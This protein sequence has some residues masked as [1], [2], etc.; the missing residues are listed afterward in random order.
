MDSSVAALLGALIGA[1]AGLLGQV[2]AA[3]YASRNERRRIAVDLG[4]REW[5]RMVEYAK[6][7][8]NAEIFPLALFVHYSVELMRV[9]D[10]RRGLTATSYADIVRSNR[11]VKES[12]RAMQ[13]VD[14][15]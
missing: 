2:I 8:P 13:P 9:L 1:G 4:I 3:R 7:H 14:R 6:N 10:L 11:A 15:S 12:I 5:D